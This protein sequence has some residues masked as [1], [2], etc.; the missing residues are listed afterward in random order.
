MPYDPKHSITT[1][2]K[3]GNVPIIGGAS[4]DPKFSKSA[5]G[6]YDA[7]QKQALVDLG[8][9][10]PLHDVVI[11]Q[12]QQAADRSDGGIL[13]PDVAQRRPEE[14]VVVAAGPGNVTYNGVSCPVAVKRGDRVRFQP[15][16]FGNAIRFPGVPTPEKGGPR[17]LEMREVDIVGYWPAE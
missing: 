11:V 3:S 6:V 5:G 16:A 2:L 1:Q 17:L 8:S 10:R 9:Y 13:L 7:T 4:D 14:G 15:Q 12:F